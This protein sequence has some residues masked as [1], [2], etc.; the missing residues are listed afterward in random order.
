MVEPSLSRTAFIDPASYTARII[1]HLIISESVQSPSITQ[2][3]SA[4]MRITRMAAKTLCAC[5]LLIQAKDVPVLSCICTADHFG[6]R[7]GSQP[8]RVIER[9]MDR[10]LMSTLG[11]AK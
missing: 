4:R 6:Q 9:G 1:K 11:P 8:M 5:I 3:V 2:Q 10:Y 7:N